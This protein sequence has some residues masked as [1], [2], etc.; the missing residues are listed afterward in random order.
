[1]MQELARNAYA[2][3]LPLVQHC[4]IHS[5]RALLHAALEG[6]QRGLV[7]VD[8]LERPSCAIICPVSGFYFGLGKPDRR[9]L[10]VFLPTLQAEYLVDKC[11]LL[12]TSTAWEAALDPLLPAKSDRIGFVYQPQSVANFPAGTGS[13]PPGFTL[14]PMD[15]ATIAKWQP[16]LDPW[17]VEI[18]DGTEGFAARSF[19]Y[20]IL[21]EDRI[22]SFCA[23]CGIGGGEA[24]V[25]I[26]TVPAYWGQGLATRVG[27]AFIDECRARG[28]TPGWNCSVGNE[29]SRV[30]GRRLGFFEQERV[31]GYALGSR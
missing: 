11:T 7:F 9:S 4:E 10:E 28:L 16:G 3:V 5:H 26:G 31:A 2:R 21:H 12:A 22:V 24:E 25:E 1:M 29:A 30:V 18:Y 8:E 6:N 17:V 23:A 13:P 19:G 20:A 27:R 15:P 14:A